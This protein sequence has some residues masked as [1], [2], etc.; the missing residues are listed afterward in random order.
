MWNNLVHPSINK[1]KWTEAEK[2]SLLSIAERYQYKDWDTI[3]EKLQTNRTAWQCLQ[4]YQKE[5]S[6]TN[7]SGPWTKE[8]DDLLAEVVEACRVGNY[9]PWHQVAYYLE[10]R[11]KCQIQERWKRTKLARKGQWRILEDMILITAVKKHGEDWIKV[12]QYLPGRTNNQCRERYKNSLKENL[13]LG[14]WTADEDKKL[15]KVVNEIGEGKWSKVAQYLPGRTDNS[16]YQRYRLI[17]A[18]VPNALDSINT[19]ENEEVSC[20]KPLT[21]TVSC[22]KKIE[23]RNIVYR[24]LQDQILNLKM[25]DPSTSTN[26][27]SENL[28]GI[29]I[30]T[31]NKLLNKMLPSLKAKSPNPKKKSK[32]EKSIDAALDAFLLPLALNI[33]QKPKIK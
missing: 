28:N 16:I 14:S 8:E 25:E 33:F 9:V 18:K 19:E 7:A 22:Q 3:A 30:T 20:S 4:K 32:K 13:M 27:I 17:K 29:D 12:A 11:S 31:I 10:G 23:R 21:R 15:M 1:E 6:K 5:V 2:K 24:A 26:S